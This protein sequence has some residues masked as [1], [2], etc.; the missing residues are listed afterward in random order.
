[1]LKKWIPKETYQN[2]IQF[3]EKGKPNQS[4]IETFQNNWF[5]IW[6]KVKSVAKHELHPFKKVGYNT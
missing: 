1:M 4:A 2:K 6:Q 5:S 3:I